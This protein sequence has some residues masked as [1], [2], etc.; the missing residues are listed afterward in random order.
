M[1]KDGSQVWIPKDPAGPPE[2]VVPQ[3]EN[4]VQ[5][6]I[7]GGTRESKL[8]RQHVELTTKYNAVIEEK[9]KAHQK[10]L[11]DMKKEQQKM[12][13]MIENLLKMQTTQVGLGAGESARKE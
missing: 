1:G 13:D 11:E 10:E 5:S 12:K 6:S 2:S 7:T 4:S 9:E 8:N 3:Q